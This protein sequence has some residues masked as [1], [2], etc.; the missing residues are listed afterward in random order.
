MQISALRLAVLVVVAAGE[1]GELV[2]PSSAALR[3]PLQRA[4]NKDGEELL[5]T[6]EGD[7]P[8]GQFANPRR[9]RPSNEVEDKVAGWLLTPVMFGCM[10][11][12]ALPF[13]IWNNERMS[14]KQEAFIKKA[15]DHCVIIDDVNVEPPEILV[16]HVVFATGTT[17]QQETLVDL[18]FPMIQ[19]DN[20]VRLRRKVEMFQ[21]TNKDEQNSK[22]GWAEKK[23]ESNQLSRKMEIINPFNNPEMPIPSSSRVD[24]VQAPSGSVKMGAFYCGAFVRRDM[25]N[26]ETLDP[27]LDKFD[28]DKMKSCAALAGMNLQTTIIDSFVYFSE[29]KFNPAD[30]KIGNFRVS[31]EVLKCGPLS[32]LGVLEKKDGWSLLPLVHEHCNHSHALCDDLTCAK[33]Q[34][35]HWTGRKEDI[36][37][38]TAAVQKIETELTD[39]ERSSLDAQL[40]TQQTEDID[41]TNVVS[42]TT[43]TWLQ[44]CLKFGHEDFIPLSEKSVGYEEFI[45][46]TASNSVNTARKNRVTYVL[47]GLCA[48]FSILAPLLVLFSIPICWGFVCY[49]PGAPFILILC[50]GG[51]VCSCSL[52][53]LIMAVS[54]IR[55]RPLLSMFLFAWCALACATL[56]SMHGQ[57]AEQH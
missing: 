24:C 12:C 8:E 11:W 35:P 51:F 7:E 57:D 27:I 20:A 28:V 54:F 29:G 40:L 37:V 52:T 44:K 9:L 30:A 4:W 48:T 14:V 42:G 33:R 6:S 46:T 10:I 45:S 53:S 56:F 36:S 25:T 31:I 55:F 15:K 5:W 43:K 23:M 16:D 32:V 26:W 1:S 50:T 41:A 2:T 49:Y 39:V 17:S 13:L 47:A 21:V 34:N 18:I 3:G 22:M 19:A 38:L